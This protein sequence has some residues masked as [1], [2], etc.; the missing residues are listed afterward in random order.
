MIGDTAHHDA[1]TEPRGNGLAAGK[2]APGAEDQPKALRT[3]ATN[4]D[5]GVILYGA[6]ADQEI[7][8]VMKMN[9]EEALS[10]YLP[11]DVPWTDQTYC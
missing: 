3:E 9:R 10:S 2:A 1:H 6:E 5:T 11:G 4:G 7:V 8:R